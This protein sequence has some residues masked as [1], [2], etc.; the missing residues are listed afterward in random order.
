[1]EIKDILNLEPYSISHSAKHNMLN[2]RMWDLTRFHYNNSP[3]YRKMF[4]ATGLDINS[5]LTMS[6]YHTCPYAFSRNL[7]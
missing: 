1:M 5:L 3:E 4:D 6:N 7:N 2:E